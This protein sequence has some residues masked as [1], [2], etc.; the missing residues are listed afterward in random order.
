LERAAAEADADTDAGAVGEL[1]PLGAVH[2]RLD[3]SLAVAAAEGALD[4]GAERG[5]GAV[6]IGGVGREVT[7]RW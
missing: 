7:G 3:V 1:D 2:D 4:A 6:F 5:E